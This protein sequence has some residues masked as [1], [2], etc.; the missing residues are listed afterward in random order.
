MIGENLR[1]FREEVYQ[2]VANCSHGI[3]QRKCLPSVFVPQILPETKLKSCGLMALVEK[4]SSQPNID[5]VM[6]LL[7]ITLMKIYNEKIKQD[8]KD[9]QKEK[10]EEKIIPGN[11]LEPSPVFKERKR[12]KKN[13]VLNGVKGV[14]TSG[15]ELILLSFQLVKRMKGKLRARCGGTH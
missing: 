14:E 8:K 3:W 10:F 2:S 7:V 5:Y 15:R 13:W 12:L 4:I 11:V 6:W 9:K 1:C